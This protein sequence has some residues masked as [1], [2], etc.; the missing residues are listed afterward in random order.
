MSC[1]DTLVKAWSDAH[2]EYSLALEGLPDE[3]L[4]K[5]PHPGLLSIGEI[6]GHVVYWEA[7]Y[8]FGPA[9]DPLFV[10]GHEGPL[11]HPKFRYYTHSIGNPVVLDLDVAGV[12][13]EFERVH[14]L[15]KNAVIAL[16]PQLT[17]P[18]PWREG[19]DWDFQLRYAAFHPA[20]H[21]GQA[22]SVR[23]MMGQ[24]TTDN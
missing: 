16:A 22:Y 7:Q 20:Y 11:L 13:A 8:I 10:A 18:I 17:D 19:A 1:L 9:E 24:T 5:R 3:D 2:W 4:W 15:A 6:T 12:L 23:H 14:E 21:A